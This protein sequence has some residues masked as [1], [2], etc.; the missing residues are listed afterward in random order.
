MKSNG[1]DMHAFSS[2]ENNNR[3]IWRPILITADDQKLPWLA[4]NWDRPTSYLSH[5][6]HRVTYVQL[7][8][9]LKHGLR[10]IDFFNNIPNTLDSGRSEE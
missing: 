2:V 4:Q 5:A 7:F 3:I 8:I 10:T 9:D 6:E 1:G